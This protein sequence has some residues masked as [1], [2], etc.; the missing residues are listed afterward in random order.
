MTNSVCQRRLPSGTTTVLDDE[1]SKRKDDWKKALC[2]C[3]YD[4]IILMRQQIQLLSYAIRDILLTS[5]SESAIRSIFFKV[6]I[7]SQ[8]GKHYGRAWAPRALAPPQMDRTDDHS[9]L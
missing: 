9:C 6:Q 8:I 5:E 2:D 3:I 1:R 4:L 7:A